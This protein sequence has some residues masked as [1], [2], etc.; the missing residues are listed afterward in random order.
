MTLLADSRP[1]P[2]WEPEAAWPAPRGGRPGFLARHVDEFWPLT[3]YAYLYPLWWVLGISKVILF[4]FTVPM[5]WALLRH[6]EVRVPRGFGVYAVFL[7]WVT[8]GVTM[9]WVRAP[10]TED[11]SGLTPLV[12]FTYRGLWYAA[13]TIACL[14]VLNADRTRFTTVR[15]V[16]LLGFL[17]VVTTAGGLL[18]VLMP[19]LDFPSMLE[20][21]LPKSFT[22]QE[23]MNALFHPRVALQSEFLG[24][25][26]PRVTAPFS[27]P[28]TWG[29]A[30]GL[31]VPFFVFAWFG[32]SA[33]W[34]RW[35]GP[36]ILLAS[37]VPVVYSLNRGLW[38]GL[39]V[40]AVWL[41]VRRLA[42]GDLRALVAVGLAAGLVA[43][44]LVA[45]PLGATINNRLSTPHSDSR[46]QDT[47]AQ[48][49][50]TTL[51]S[52]PV[53]GYGGTRQ[54]VGNFT[55]IAGGGTPGCHQCSAPPLGTQGFLWGLIFMTG[56]VGAGLMLLFLGWQIWINARRQST[57]A[58]LTSTVLV[59]SVFYFLF[60][61]ALDLPML[62]TMIAIGLSSRE[63]ALDPTRPLYPPPLAEPVDL[64]ELD[65]PSDPDQLADLDDLDD[66]DD[67]DE[68]DDYDEPD[69]VDLDEP[70][71][72]PVPRDEPHEVP[73]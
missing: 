63:H 32:R 71:E 21:F 53:L 26:Q 3:T 11:K 68:L 48:V 12:G 61:D 29:N 50:R 20:L 70:D 51:T 54:M 28:N 34:R 39:G 57:L 67:Y 72:T 18:G 42:A 44:G 24:Y 13:V 19:H 6:R 1:A 37:F 59:S 27:Y 23:F 60:Y 35:V 31:L 8:L 30:Y 56:F 17:F 55:S 38:L 36:L 43:I 46:R 22:K 16:R 49:I 66:Y 62:V 14:Y 15:I 33:G 5:L 45:T 69:D 52:S 7:L 65:D 4:V 64:D 73:R 47:A 9:L 41:V 2:T 40:S 25:S 58:L 10:G